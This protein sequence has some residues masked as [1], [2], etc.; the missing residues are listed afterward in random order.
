MDNTIWES[1]QW[2]Q[3]E[4]ELAALAP[5]QPLSARLQQVLSELPQ[6]MQARILGEALLAGEERVAR[7]V[8]ESSGR[9]AV[10][11]TQDGW[12][13]F[14]LTLGQSSWKLPDPDKTVNLFGQLAE[15]SRDSFFSLI[16]ESGAHGLIGYHGAANYA[17]ETPHI[18]DH[19]L[20]RIDLKNQEL[21][22]HLPV[23]ADG[24]VQKVELA[25]VLKAR[26]EAMKAPWFDDVLCWASQDMIDT[27][28][29]ELHPIWHEW[30]GVCSL[31]KGQEEIPMAEI[32]GEYLQKTRIV[33]DNDDWMERRDYLRNNPDSRLLRRFHIHTHSS[34]G[35]LTT[36]DAQLL[37]QQGDH[38]LWDGF[39]PNAEQTKGLQLCRSSAAF[40][41]SRPN[42]GVE[43]QLMREINDVCRNRIPFINGVVFGDEPGRLAPEKDAMKPRDARTV[44]QLGSFYA[45]SLAGLQGIMPPDLL[46]QF[47][48]LDNGKMSL[49][50]LSNLWKQGLY[51]PGMGATVD[52]RSMLS[53]YASVELPAGCNVTLTF[54]RKDPVEV[55]KALDLLYTNAKGSVTVNG[56]PG[57]LQPSH[58]W[59]QLPKADQ[60]QRFVLEAL[61]RFKGHKLFQQFANDENGF[62]L[63]HQVFGGEALAD[64]FDELPERL[65]S[66]AAAGVLGI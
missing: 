63:M 4:Q 16:I 39:G 55:R 32:T 29:D 31:R 66:V 10:Q 15:D 17:A 45:K 53:T 26:G 65:Q 60:E 20:G 12:F 35:K 38:H 2:K 24:V 23:Y 42:E 62:E 28:P 21:V 25:K 59:A 50:T 64:R 48:Q 3:A 34:T 6:E 8:W 46:D 44:L 47:V 18:D 57:T 52:S 54:A 33:G 61:A 43:P 49:T 40:L 9:P 19:A 51:T 41:A 11:I 30:I 27:Y 7:F 37:K 56:V 58:I 13:E 5:R 1:R 36:R 14:H 22:K